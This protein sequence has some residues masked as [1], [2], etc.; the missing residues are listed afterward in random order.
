MSR[1]FL[2]DNGGVELS[3]GT[4]VALADNNRKAFSVAESEQKISTDKARAG[5]SEHVVRYVLIASLALAVV[6]MVIILVSW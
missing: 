4:R 3:I 5:S 6:A 2:P 1:R